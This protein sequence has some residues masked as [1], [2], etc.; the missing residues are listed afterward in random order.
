MSNKTKDPWRPRETL[1][2]TVLLGGGRP[3]DGGR[4]MKV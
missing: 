1:K 4:W 3:V 2:H